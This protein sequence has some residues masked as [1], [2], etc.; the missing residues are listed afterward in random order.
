MDT[1]DE[2]LLP[3][4]GEKSDKQKRDAYGSSRQYQYQKDGKAHSRRYDRVYRALCQSPAE[5]VA[6][7]PF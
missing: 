7:S 5:K 1:P 2:D 3:G 4:R 6:L